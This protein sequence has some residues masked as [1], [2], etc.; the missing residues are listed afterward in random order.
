MGAVKPDYKTP[1]DYFNQLEEKLKLI[2]EQNESIQTQKKWVWVSLAASLV[3]AFCSIGYF[4][5]KEEGYQISETDEFIWY[6]GL[7][8]QSIAEYSESEIELL[9]ERIE[10]EQ[11][12]EITIEDNEMYLNYLYDETE[13]N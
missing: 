7:F 10:E 5:L 9:S 12:N 13:F 8:E 1:P 6:P 2:P 4:S 11:W 3:L